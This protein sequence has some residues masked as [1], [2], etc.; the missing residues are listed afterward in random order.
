M[1]KKSWVAYGLLSAIILLADQVTKYLVMT[2]M[3]VGTAKDIIPHFFRVVSVRNAGIVF[4]LFSQGL[5]QN[6]QKVFIVFTIIAM[7]AIVVYSNRKKNTESSDFYPL[8]LILGGAAGNLLDRLIHGR[9]VDFLDFYIHG[10]HWPAFN[11][12]DSGIVIG[13]SLLLLF[14]LFEEK[15]QKRASFDP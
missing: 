3:A 9:V 15:R 5:A 4:G 12:A 7:G 14:Q 1:Y 13:V 11:I 6:N 2:Q 8:A 10:Y